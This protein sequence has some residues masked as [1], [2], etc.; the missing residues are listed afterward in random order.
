MKHSHHRK[1]EQHS[2]RQSSSLVH[3]EGQLEIQSEQE[4]LEAQTMHLD[5]NASV[6]EQQESKSMKSRPIDSAEAQIFPVPVPDA[7]TNSIISN[8]K[9]DDKRQL[10]QSS[11]YDQTLDNCSSQILPLIIMQ[12]LL[13]VDSCSEKSESGEIKHRND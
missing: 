1:Y 8:P 3:F 6:V 4:T 10:Q 5:G 13:D 11:S 12:S 9:N 7:T 2:N